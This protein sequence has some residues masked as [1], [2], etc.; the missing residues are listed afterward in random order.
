MKIISSNVSKVYRIKKTFFR[1][2]K[3]KVV[4]NFN[5]CI[6]QGEI[7]GILGAER[8]GKSTIV[9]LLCGKTSPTSGK[10]E[11]V[12]ESLCK[13]LKGNCELISDLD[14]KKLLKNESVYNN[15]I[16]Y[17][18][19]FK[20]NSFDVEKS[21]SVLK[22]LFQLDTI[23]NER[24][25]NISRLDKIKVNIMI[26]MLKNTPFL[27]FDSALIDLDIVDRNVILKILKRLNKEYKTTI[28][29]SSNNLSDIEK[30]CKRVTYIKNG[31]ILKDE[32]LDDLKKEYGNTKE[33]KMVFNK[34]FITP[35]GDFEIL[36]NNE[37]FLKVRV[38]FDKCDFSTLLS[39]FDINTIIDI[40]ISNVFNI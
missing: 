28:I 33:I 17:G 25:E 9:N 19:K 24:I 10:V 16:Y 5:Y 39:Q 29:V 7:V 1:F 12:G 31:C 2:D 35:K 20:L 6:S 4:E 14:G 26:S 15:F 36:E 23:I 11:I 8:S 34:S 27:F 22:E 13:T 3:I 30:I 38:N 32:S 37:Y 40:N 18:N 21:V